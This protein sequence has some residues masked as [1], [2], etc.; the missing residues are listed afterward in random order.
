MEKIKKNCLLVA[1]DINEEPRFYIV[2]AI[3]AGIAYCKDMYGNKAEF[4]E[5]EIDKICE[6]KGYK[7]I[8]RRDGRFQT[9]ISRPYDDADYYWA[10]T[11]DL[12]NWEI[13]LDCK[14]REVFTGS[15]EQAVDRIAELNKT[16]APKI[17]HN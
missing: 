15:F 12:K 17:I 4:A 5:D 10:L 9:S 13:I 2:Y 11:D 3:E 1:K 8:F 7:L 6:H 16:I 14:K